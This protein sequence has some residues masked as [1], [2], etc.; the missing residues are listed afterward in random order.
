MWRALHG[1]TM[2]LITGKAVTRPAGGYSALD[3]NTPLAS[4]G[5]TDGPSNGLIG[6][7]AVIPRSLPKIPGQGMV[8]I[9]FKCDIDLEYHRGRS[10]RHC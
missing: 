10:V 7:T 8:A 3:R 2:T 1:N 5:A 4:I 9:G 6:Q